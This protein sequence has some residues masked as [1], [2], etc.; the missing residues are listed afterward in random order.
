MHDR[1]TLCWRKNQFWHILSL[2]WTSPAQSSLTEKSKVPPTVQHGDICSMGSLLSRASKLLCPGLPPAAA[3]KFSDSSLFVPFLWP[4]TRSGSFI[5]EFLGTFRSSVQTLSQRQMVQS[6]WHVLHKGKEKTNSCSCG[7]QQIT[8][9][10]NLSGSVDVTTIK[11]IFAEWEP[12]VTT[13]AKINY[14]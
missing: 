14:L 4:H 7:W 2:H 3:P 5:S 10:F 1:S 13:L 8:S 12:K 11:F 9:T 6:F